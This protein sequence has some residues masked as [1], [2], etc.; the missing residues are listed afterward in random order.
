MGGGKREVIQIGKTK[1]DHRFI[2]S[3]LFPHLCISFDE[4]CANKLGSAFRDHE[5][6]ERKKERGKKKGEGKGRKRKERM[7]EEGKEEGR[8]REGGGEKGR[9]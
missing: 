6:E 7:K 8:R 9:R 3:R 2:H 4:L 5:E 1:E